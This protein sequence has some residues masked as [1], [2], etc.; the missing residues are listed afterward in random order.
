MPNLS[1]ND[2]LH[3]TPIY[4]LLETPMQSP[5][6][7]THN[8]SQDHRPQTPDN[9]HIANNAEDMNDST[10]IQYESKMPESEEDKA[11]SS[12]STQQ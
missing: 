9:H 1:S 10:G 2:T 6:E 5:T 12:F 8:T 7:Q 4:T 3:K 11:N